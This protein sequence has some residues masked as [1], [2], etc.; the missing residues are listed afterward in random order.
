MSQISATGGGAKVENCGNIIVNIN[1][2][3]RGTSR[4]RFTERLEQV[5]DIAKVLGLHI[6]GS[7]NQRS[8]DSRI[9]TLT[10]VGDECR[11]EKGVTK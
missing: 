9:V 5:R 6:Q 10:S 2:D 3:M 7:A 11:T 8:A 1:I 4:E